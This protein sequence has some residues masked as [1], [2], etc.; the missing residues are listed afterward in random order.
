[1]C[2]DPSLGPVTKAKAWKGVG[3]KCSS[4]V[5]F[6][7]PRVWESVKEW[8]H[9][10]PSGFPFWELESQ[11]ICKF[12]YSDLKVQNSLDWIFPYTI[13]NLL[14]FICLKWARMMHLSI[15]NTSYG[16]KKGRKS[17]CQFDFWPLKVKNCPELHVC[18]RHATYHWKILDEGYNFA[19]D[20]TSI[21]GL[22]KKLWASKMAK[23]PISVLGKSPFECS[24]HRVSQRIL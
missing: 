9:T 24:P 2:H 8:A 15:Y 11:W 1:M 19:L 4:G 20:L 18:K 7:F 17:K 12:S 5:T 10:F 13:G 22:Y 21:E 23:I 6:T 16:Q 14:K 3:R